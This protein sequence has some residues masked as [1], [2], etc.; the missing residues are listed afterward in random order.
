MKTAALPKTLLFSALTAA[1]AVASPASAQELRFNFDPEHFR[2]DPRTA[3]ATKA[4]AR[5]AHIMLKSRSSKPIPTAAIIAGSRDLPG[6]TI[7]AI[8]SVGAALSRGKSPGMRQGSGVNVC[9]IA[10]IAWAIS[11]KR[12][13]SAMRRE[14]SDVNIA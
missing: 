14:E 13:R 6:M 11:T 1:I 4:S 9:R 3:E 12:E 2:F 8:I 10:L 7:P 5:A